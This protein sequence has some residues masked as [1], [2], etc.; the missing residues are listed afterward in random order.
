MLIK[1]GADP[2]GDN[3]SHHGGNGAYATL[4][5]FLT[6]YSR[7]EPLRAVLE[8]SVAVNIPN[9]AGRTAMF[10]ASD[11]KIVSLL[12]QAGHSVDWEDVRGFRPIHEFLSHNKPFDVIK[13]LLDAKCDPNAAD[14][15]GSTPLHIMCLQPDEYLRYQTFGLYDHEAAFEYR[16]DRREKVRKRLDIFKLLVDYGASFAAKDN[17]GKTPLDVLRIDLSED[18]FPEWKAIKDYITEVFDAHSNNHGFKRA[19]ID[20]GEE[21]EEC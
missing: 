20:V 14:V 17:E 16:A 10:F 9:G 11:P 15:N 4:T 2:S 21:A 12:F 18:Y 19:R 7:K 8:S 5:H 3:H 6:V 1:Q 13:A